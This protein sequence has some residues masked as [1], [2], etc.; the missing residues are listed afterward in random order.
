MYA[1]ETGQYGTT[2]KALS[3]A[4]ALI[5]VIACVNVAGLM[6][7]RGATR[8]V[9]LAIRAS[10]GAG[11]GRLFRQ[12]LTESVLLAFAGAVAG[13][14]LAYA[15]LDSLLAIIPLSLPPNSPA[16]INSAVLAFALGLTVVTA[17]LFGLVPALKLVSCTND[18]QLDAVASRPRRCAAVQARGPVSHRRRGPSG[19]R[20]ARR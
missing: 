8:D 16:T 13:V 15:S 19:T 3:L 12:L 20:S 11:R 1:K 2:I 6:L 5:L 14:L 10:I 9:E 17:L 18:D 4:V 7:A